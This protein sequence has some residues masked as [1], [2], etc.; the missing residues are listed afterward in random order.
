M[1][2]QIKNIQCYL[3]TNKIIHSSI[4]LFPYI[5]EHVFIITFLE[6]PKEALVFYHMP[7]WVV[8]YHT[9]S[10]IKVLGETEIEPEIL[11]G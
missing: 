9:S 6:A 8:S 10:N 1:T 2:S 4:F 5:Q 11:T 7:L 3:K